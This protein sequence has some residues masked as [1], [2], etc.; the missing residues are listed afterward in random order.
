MPHQSLGVL[1]ETALS[2]VIRERKIAIKVCGLL[3]FDAKP[4]QNLH[5]GGRKQVADATVEEQLQS[6]KTPRTG[7]AAYDRDR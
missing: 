7:F 5:C 4:S 1:F 3:L 6:R 2:T